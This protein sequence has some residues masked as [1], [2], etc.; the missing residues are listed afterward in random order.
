LVTIT[1]P[2]N[3]YLT[4][5]GTN[6]SSNVTVSAW[7]YNNERMNVAVKLVISGK[8]M[9][10]ANNNS[11]QITL[12]TSTDGPITVPVTI[13]GSGMPVITGNVVI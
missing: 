1:P 13:T 7:N 3:T 12:Y 4:Y 8:N 5:S 2:A 9:M 10:F 11:Q 6:L